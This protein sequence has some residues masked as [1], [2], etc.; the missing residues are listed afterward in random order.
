M[1][2]P[3]FLRTD[4]LGFRTWSLADLDL[5]QELWGDPAVTRWIG[6]PFSPAGVEER[7]RLE[8]ATQASG[9]IQYWP[10]FLLASGEHVGCC[11]LRPYDA[12]NAILELG[13][14]IRS[15]HWRHGYAA[16]AARAVIRT[17][18]ERLGA[19]ALF[20]GHHPD[21]DASRRLLEKL[22]F[23]YTHDEMYPPTGKRHPS[24]RLERG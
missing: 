24:Y 10:V 17:A 3:W 20:A 5:A 11:G 13:F 2:D 18:F 14:H 19:R 7:L 6:G 23:R 9:G 16:E 12:E 1:S 15:A 21:N 8:I 4:R 22:G